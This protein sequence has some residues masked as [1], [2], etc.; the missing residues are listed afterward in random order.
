[1]TRNMLD[2]L[3]KHYSL[4]SRI[5]EGSFS[6]VLKVKSRETGEF[7]AAKRLTNPFASVE[8][9]ENYSELI[10]LR[11]LDYHPNILHLVDYIFESDTL[12][13]VFNLMDMSFYDFIKDRK[14]KLSESR[15]KN[16]IYQ[17]LNGVNYLH[18]NGIFHR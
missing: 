11:K 13:L 6:E 16:Y 17:L 15:C 12:T 9:V 18:Q 5:G 2:S 7:F 4:I 3:K 10:I 1:M 8:D 14:R